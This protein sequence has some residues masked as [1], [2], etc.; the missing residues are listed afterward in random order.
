MP[1]RRDACATVMPANLSLWPAIHVDFLFELTALM[2]PCRRRGSGVTLGRPRC[3]AAQ[4]TQGHAGTVRLRS[5]GRSG[6]ESVGSG[7]RSFPSQPSTRP[8]RK[9]Y[10]IERRGLE[11]EGGGNAEGG[12]EERGAH[13]AVESWETSLSRI[14]I[15]EL[16]ALNLLS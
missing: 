15:S 16:P 5:E 1:I 10:R 12:D 6:G 13:L 7:V 8:A 11:V 4:Q 2:M 9:T 14:S 3:G